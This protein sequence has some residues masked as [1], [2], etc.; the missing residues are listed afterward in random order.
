MLLCGS[1]VLTY[2]GYKLRSE[3]IW[4]KNQLLLT[5]SLS[6]SLFGKCLNHF[7]LSPAVDE[8]CG[9]P[10]PLCTHDCRLYFVTAPLGD[11][12]DA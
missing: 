11:V 6:A 3:I 2:Q 1:Y 8:S 10:G 12:E 9:I 4:L 7:A 5:F